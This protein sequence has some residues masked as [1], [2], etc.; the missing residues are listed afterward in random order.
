[1]NNTIPLV[2]FAKVIRRRSPQAADELYK[3]DRRSRIVPAIWNFKHN[4]FNLGI[5]VRI[6]I[7]YPQE[8]KEPW[9]LRIYSKTK[10]GLLATYGKE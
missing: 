7:P 3:N 5:K 9:R 8:S 10:Y 2:R 6:P 1:M 4:C